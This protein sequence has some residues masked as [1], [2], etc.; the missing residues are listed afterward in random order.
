MQHFITK[1]NKNLNNQLQIIDLEEI[2]IVNKAQKSILCLNGSLRK[3]R[4]VILHHTFNNEEE[5]ILFF[6]DIKPKIF[7]QLIYHVKI[8]NIEGKRP[9]GSFEIQQKYLLNEL[10]KL[11]IFFNSHLEFYRYYRS[12][13]IFLDDKLFV[14]GREDF[15]FHQDN[16]FVYTDPEFST[17][18][19]YLVAEIMANDR[20]EVYLKSELDTLTI[21]NSNPNWSQ[22]GMLGNFSLQWTDDKISLVELIYAIDAFGSINKGQCEISVL[23]SF[24]EQAFNVRLSDVYR[25]YIDIRGREIPTKYLDNLR[26][27]LR[28]KM[29]LGPF[30]ILPLTLLIQNSIEF[31]Y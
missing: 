21:K 20:L 18:V 27:A 26:A 31:L 16:P 13:S 10:E 15:H 23:T 5:E 8:N 29:G 24:F 14:R 11:T 3:L 25:T 19:D 9:M 1:L 28:Q 6:K 22:L 17:S 4:T 2:S 12:N 30:K 7:C